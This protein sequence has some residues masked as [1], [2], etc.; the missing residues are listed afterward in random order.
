MWTLPGE[1]ATLALGAAL[2]AVLQ[3]G[4]V[5]YLSGDLGTGKTTLARGLLR[6]LGHSGPVKSPT[7]TLVELYLIS[8]YSVYHFD[9][10]RFNTPEEWHD[11]GLEEHFDGRAICLVEWPEKVGSDL[12]AP[13]ICI[14]LNVYGDARQVSIKGS[15][16]RGTTCL[17]ELRIPSS[18][19]TPS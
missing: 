15:S 1:D 10:Y 12:P 19:S 17:S 13:D 8:G 9:F 16:E 11:A 18:I 3:P 2:A 14:H 5:I 4:L 7:Y 6:A